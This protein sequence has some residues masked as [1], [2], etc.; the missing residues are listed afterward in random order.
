MGQ[1]KLND[2]EKVKEFLDEI[3]VPEDNRVIM[4][5]EEEG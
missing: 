1:A 5:L 3:E 4:E 2:V